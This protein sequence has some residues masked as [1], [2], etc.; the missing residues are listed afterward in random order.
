MRIALDTNVIVSHLKDDE[1]AE[2]TRSFLKWAKATKQSLL[3]S[4]IVYS[5]LY[6][7]IE[8]SA[9][10]RLEER[11]VQRFLAVN[12]IEV[13]LHGSLDVAKRSGRIYANYLTEVGAA[14][15]RILPDFL[16]GAHAEIY[17]EV[18]ATWNPKDFVKYLKVPVLTPTQITQRYSFKSEEP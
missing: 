17:G 6:A 2:G 10:P 16:V 12:R 14:R 8:L 3:I 5:E 9:D 11:R 1:F 15:E 13:R 4:E 7:G 18:L